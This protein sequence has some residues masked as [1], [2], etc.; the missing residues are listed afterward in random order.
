[1]PRKGRPAT[2]TPRAARRLAASGISPSPQALSSGGRRRSRTATERPA[3][4]AS[5]AVASPAGP[6]PTIARSAGS[7]ARPLPPLLIRLVLR[8]LHDLHS[9]PRQ[10]E[11]GLGEAR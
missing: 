1:M 5:I 4:R 6:P 3:S 10:R 7:P 2:S 9:A 8:D 11:A